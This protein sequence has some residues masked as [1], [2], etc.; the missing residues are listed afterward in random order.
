MVPMS[1]TDEYHPTTSL[2]AQSSASLAESSVKRLNSA[3]SEGKHHT[4]KL[5]KFTD[6]LCLCLCL[7]VCFFGVIWCY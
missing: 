3:A 4:G 2:S 6:V 5:I 7:F 1:Y